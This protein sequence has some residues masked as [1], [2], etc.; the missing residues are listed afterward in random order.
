MKGMINYF[1]VILLYGRGQSDTLNFN[2][3][4]EADYTFVLKFLVI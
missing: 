1:S 4:L 3:L 2:N